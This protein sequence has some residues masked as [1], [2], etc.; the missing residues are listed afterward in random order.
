MAGRI[1]T[2]QIYQQHE[3]NLS[4]AR[5]R[6][7][8]SAERAA[9]QKAVV[10]PSDNP[11][12][13]TVAHNLKE[14]ISVREALKK[15]ASLAT[16]HLT[17]A[18]Q[19]LSR[20]QEYVQKAHELALGGAGEGPLATTGRLAAITELEGLYGSLVQALNTQ[21]AGRT[22]MA[23]DMTRGPAFDL[24]GQ[25]LGDSGQFE[26]EIERNVVIPVN[27]SAEKAIQGKGLTDGVDILAAFQTLITGLKEDDVQGVRSALPG[28]LKGTD[29]ISIART[30]IAGRQSQIEKTIESH[31][32]MNIESTDTVSKIEDVDALKAFSDLSRDQVIVESALQTTKKILTEVPQDLLF[33]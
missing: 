15:N 12:G 27:V 17:A 32:L 23:G 3:A 10:R 29:Q 4:R 13:W 33:K 5:N 1:S 21:F 18:D 9:T 19:V 6:E 16:H 31:G 8:H 14:D 22:V 28:L 25:Y 20:A 24:S 30:E 11:T 26:I 2:A 7:A